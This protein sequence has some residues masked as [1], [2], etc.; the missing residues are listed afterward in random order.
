MGEGETITTNAFLEG[1]TMKTFLT[2]SM[3]AALVC[4]APA[5][6][7]DMATESG[8]NSDFRA[9]TEISVSQTLTEQE[10]ASIEGQAPIG[11]IG[12]VN[13]AAQNVLNRNDIDVNVVRNVTIRDVQVGVLAAQRQ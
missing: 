5:F 1:V 9:L 13:V 7:M 8:N 11:Q 12:L 2:I 10:L 6:A 4:A 3:F